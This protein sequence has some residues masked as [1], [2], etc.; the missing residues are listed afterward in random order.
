MKALYTSHTATFD[1][2]L[3]QFQDDSMATVK[4]L[5]HSFINTSLQ[6]YEESVEL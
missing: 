4:K 2:K 1:K 5:T 6:P 3:Q